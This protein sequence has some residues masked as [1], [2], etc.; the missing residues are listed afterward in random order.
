MRQENVSTRS[1]EA[2]RLLTQVR[3]KIRLK[4]YSIRTEQAYTDWIKR[5]IFYHKKRHP[6]QM[7]AQEITAFLTHLAVDGKVAAAT[8][9]QA[10][11]ALLFLYRDVLEVTLPWLDDIEQ[12]KI[13]I[14]VLDKGYFK[15][16]I[17]GAYEFDIAYIYFMK[18]HS[19]MHKWLAL[20]N[21]Q[22]ENYNEVTGYLKLSITIAGTGDEQVQI[23]EDNNVDKSDEAVLMPPSIKPEYY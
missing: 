21:P 22:S 23:S 1:S 8:Q 20:S 2:P 16:A 19:L 4:H 13:S 3:D 10:K 9:N 15:D 17:I 11:S 7:G 18:D 5:F 12:A 14:R 6:S